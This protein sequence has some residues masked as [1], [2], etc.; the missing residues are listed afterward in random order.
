[1]TPIRRALPLLFIP[2]I[3]WSVIAPEIITPLKLYLG[4]IIPLTAIELVARTIGLAVF[5]H[6]HP[7]FDEQLVNIEWSNYWHIHLPA[8]I[9][10]WVWQLMAIYV[11]AH[12]V[13]WIAPLFSGETNDRQ[14]LKVLAFALTPMWV[15]K[16]FFAIPIFS[17]N[18]SVPILSLCYTGYVLYLGLSILM[19]ASSPK[20]LL[21]AGT[22]AMALWGALKAP[23]FVGP[24]IGQWPVL[25]QSI[26]TMIVAL[27]ILSIVGWV[28]FYERHGKGSSLK[29]LL[30]LGLLSIVLWGASEP[31]RIGEFFRQWLFSDAPTK[32]MNVV[33]VI[34]GT[35]ALVVLY[36]KYRNVGR[37]KSD[38]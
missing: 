23:K 31:L 19:K 29:A 22:V 5:F 6:T 7:E 14:A 21:Y 32:I 28:M 34:L 17:L 12:F 30:S 4:Y 15:G 25:D 3:A 36:E 20:A 16:I 11:V 24:L 10:Q 26:Q 13:S 37:N 33:L 35:T 27:C 2:K 18:K 1:M 38:D 9:V 8:L